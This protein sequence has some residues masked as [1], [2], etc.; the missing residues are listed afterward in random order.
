MQ[1]FKI[2]HPEITWQELTELGIKRYNQ[3]EQQKF[4][5]LHKPVLKAG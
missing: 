5:E 3:L 4:Y 2:Q 1:N